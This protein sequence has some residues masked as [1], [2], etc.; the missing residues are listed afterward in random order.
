[1]D[2]YLPRQG[3]PLKPD[4]YYL[5]SDGQ[6]FLIKKSGKWRFPSRRS[7]IPYSFKPV[8]FIPLA[9]S[10]VLFA[11][12]VLKT[13]PAHWMHKDEIIGR[14]DVDPIVQRAVNRSLPRGA[15]K[16]AIIE[17]GKVLMVRAGRG[18]TKGIWNLPGGFIGYGEHPAESAQ[19]EVQEELGIR[20]KLVRLLGTYSEVFTHSGGY[21][22]SFVYL[23]KRRPGP[24]RP[25]PEEI[26]SYCWMPVKTAAR[27][28]PNPFARAG[29]RDYLKQR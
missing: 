28:T 21:M 1:L 29:L 2:Y 14:S 5:E 19:R 4:Y 25:H 24:I 11:K 22:L 16:V 15:S 8:S 10:Q 7:E 3:I 12:P 18:L 9:G 6:V 27:V 23:G 26:E 20:V 17:N 13:H